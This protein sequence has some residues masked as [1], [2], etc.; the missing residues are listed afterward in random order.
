MAGNRE[1]PCG[2]HVIAEDCAGTVRIAID[3]FALVRT[4]VGEHQLAAKEI[5]RQVSQQHRREAIAEIRSVI[6]SFMEVVFVATAK[7]HAVSEVVDRA[8][9]LHP[10]FRF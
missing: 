10:R 3:I 1:I 2:I 9:Q 8:R 7:L 5:N 6:D 4:V